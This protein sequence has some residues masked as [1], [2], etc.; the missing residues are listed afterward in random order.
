MFHSINFTSKLVRRIGIMLFLSLLISVPGSNVLAQ[1]ASANILNQAENF[2]NIDEDIKG[3]ELGVG[4][5]PRILP[6]SPFYFAKN[7]G[8]G[9]Q[10]FF[11]FNPVSKAELKLKFASEKL[12]EAKKMAEKNSDNEKIVKALNNYQKEIER[13]KGETEKKNLISVL[14]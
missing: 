13:V 9:I 7:I 1:D 5:N 14:E 2:V 4:D 3:S 10:S 6:D 12:I 8:R 11:T